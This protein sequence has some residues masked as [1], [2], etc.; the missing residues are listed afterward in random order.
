MALLCF[1]R[2]ATGLNWAGGRKE[3]VH[4]L[5]AGIIEK[6]ELYHGL[7]QPFRWQPA[8]PPAWASNLL[9]CSWESCALIHLC[10]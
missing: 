9:G 4:L 3:A 1:L 5:M 6:L 10:C 7:D 2:L 8:L